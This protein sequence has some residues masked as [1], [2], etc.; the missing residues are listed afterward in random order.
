NTGLIVGLGTGSDATLKLLSGS[1]TLGNN[2]DVGRGGNADVIV[3]GGTLKVGNNLLIGNSANGHANF[4]QTGGTITTNNA[5]LSRASVT[6]LSGGTLGVTLDLTLSLAGTTLTVRDTASVTVGSR[7]SMSNGVLNINN[8]GT[9]NATSGADLY[10]GSAG[11]GTPVVN[12]NGGTLKQSSGTTRIGAVSNSDTTVNINNGGLLDLRALLL[13]ANGNATV[14]VN[15]GGTLLLG[16]GT[17]TNIGSS[18]GATYAGNG[19]LNINGGSVQL[20]AS[21]NSLTL[22]NTVFD[23]TFRTKGTLNLL[24]GS[25]VSA[26]TLLVGEAGDGIVT[27]SG[28]TGTIN[29]DIRLANATGS[30]G[31]ITLNG[32]SLS[33]TG[34]ISAGAGAATITFNGGSLSANALLFT[35]AD[36]TFTSSL[37]ITGSVANLTL[38]NGIIVDLS[39]YTG[40]GATFDLLTYTDA[41]LE[42]VNVTF[43]LGTTPFAAAAQWD[44]GKLSVVLT[45]VPEPA[46]TALLLGLAAL[47]LALFWVHTKGAKGITKV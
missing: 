28:G 11:G 25:L 23:A 35:I 8:G 21:G 47:G 15:T 42:S 24:A 20:T 41:A 32:G 5:T 43:D 10:L 31:S 19:I 27:V 9:V 39:A 22:G 26:K 12:L 14:N 16:S 1:I 44:A 36:A 34:N 6:D 40:A 38:S 18:S 30:T 37:N 2:L 46:T 3:S 4:T 13:G 17:Y 45:A 29:N 33:A 7:F